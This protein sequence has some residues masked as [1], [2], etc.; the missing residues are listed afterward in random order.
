ML[1][2]LAGCGGGGKTDLPTQTVKGAGYAFEAPAGWTVTRAKGATSAASGAVDLVE[3]RTFKLV[4]PYRPRLFHLAARE[5]DS[6]AER[7][8]VQ[9]S[10]DVTSRRT[11]RVAGRQARSYLIA[12]DDKA[13]EI[14]FVLLGRQ[15]HQLLCR[16]LA[17]TGAVA[18]K[19][20]LESFTLR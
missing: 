18:C 20:L 1:L 16:R 6:T 3:V 14:T 4:R 12:Y 9:L 17:D 5:L 11:V 15:E 13:E 2:I 10:G 7:L 8:A 19:Q